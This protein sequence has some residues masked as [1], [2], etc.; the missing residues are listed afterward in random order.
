MAYEFNN[1]NLV[2]V[3]E[4]HTNTGAVFKPSVFSQ[5]TVALNQPD[6]NGGPGNNGYFAYVSIIAGGT[7]I[8]IGMPRLTSNGTTSEYVFLT[9]AQAQAVLSDVY[10]AVD[11]Y[12]Q[13][14]A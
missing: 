8:S 14:I 6:P 11:E 5:A 3:Y 10:L 9:D 12:Y 4:T 13:S 1:T 2:Y 7:P